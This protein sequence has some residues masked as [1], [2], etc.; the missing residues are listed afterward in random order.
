[1]KKQNLRALILTGVLAM[2]AHSHAAVQVYNITFTGDG[3]SAAGQIDVNSGVATSGYLDL[4]YGASTTDYNYLA[5]ANP[6]TPPNLAI[7]VSDDNG[8]NLPLVDNLVNPSATDFVDEYGLLFL[9]APLVGQ[10][11]AGSG[12]YFSADQ[13]NNYVPNLTGYGSAFGWGNPNVDGTASIVAAPEPTATAGFAGI[14][15]ICM[16][17]I[18]LRRKSVVAA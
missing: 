1:M 2:A 7:I 8:D 17:L 14:S 11:S 6:A 15:A 16:L 13:N 9:T 12:I 5:P 10:H 3:Y 18:A 4:T